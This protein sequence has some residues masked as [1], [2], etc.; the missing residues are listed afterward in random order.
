M[1]KQELITYRIL[2]KIQETSNTVSLVFQPSVAS[3]NYRAGQFITFVFDHLGTKPIR[4]SYSLSSTPGLDKHWQITVKRQVNGIVSNYLTEQVQVGDVLYGLPPAGQFTLNTSNTGGDIFL[5]GGGSG[6][7][8]LFGLMRA[9]LHFHSQ[10]K[11]TLIQAERSWQ[12]LIFREQLAQ[13]QAAFPD[14]LRTIILL[15]NPD[16]TEQYPASVDVRRAR[17]GNALVEDLVGKYLEGSITKAQCFVCGPR[18]LRLKAVMALRFMGF[19]DEQVKREIFVIRESPRPEA[20]KFPRAQVK[21]Q[22]RGAS[23]SFSVEPGETVLRAA[24]R[25]GLELPYSCRS[26]ICTTCSGQCVSG[27]A[28]MYSQEGTFAAKP[29]QQVLL[30]V[31]YPLSD[32]EIE[33][34]NQTE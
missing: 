28:M 7:T 19:Q 17:L 11:V 2:D 33:L 13:L 1:A 12:Q 27:E 10:T 21:L 32:V 18:G 22:W 25:A 3:Q 14:R 30:C 6:I 23:Y 34:E 29:K 15:S 4:R 9:A 24:E 8:P 5:I 26:G 20:D 31:A 16:D